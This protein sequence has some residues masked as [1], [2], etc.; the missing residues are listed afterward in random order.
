LFVISEQLGRY[1]ET[2]WGIDASRMA[3]LPNCVDP[4]R[5]MIADPQQ[6]E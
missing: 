2:N 3:L 4:E 6:I 5:F 1:V